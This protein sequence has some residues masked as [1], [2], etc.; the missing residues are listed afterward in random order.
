MWQALILSFVAGVLGANGTPHFIKGITK[1]QFP[2]SL[3]NTPSANLVAGWFMYVLTAVALV[4]AHP[5]HHLAAAIAGAAVGVLLM[6][7][8][9]SAI[10]A[11]GKNGSRPPLPAAPDMPIARR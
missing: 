6:G 10:G 9:H 7:L 4:Y 3:G 2:N 5:Q 8:F 11:F 1:E